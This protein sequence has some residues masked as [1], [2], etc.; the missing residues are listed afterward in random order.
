MSDTNPICPRCN[1]PMNMGNSPNSSECTETDDD[2]GLCE[3]YAKIWM[4]TKERD[5]ARARIEELN[6]MICEYQDKAWE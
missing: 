6:K 1:R 5:G 2:D 3:A 4:L